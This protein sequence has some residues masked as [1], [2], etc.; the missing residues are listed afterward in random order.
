[1]NVLAI[2]EFIH[3]LQSHMNPLQNTHILVLLLFKHTWT[4]EY[5]LAHGPRLIQTHTDR[6]L[7]PALVLTQTYL[8]CWAIPGT[9]VKMFI[10]A[11]GGNKNAP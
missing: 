9:L 10:S 5:I 6:L 7:G 11:H 8:V 2:S 1:M 4:S 3:L